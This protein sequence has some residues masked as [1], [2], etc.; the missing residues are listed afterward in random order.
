[1]PALRGLDLTIPEGSLYALLG[2][3]GAGKTTL[4]RILAGMLRPSAGNAVVLG[5]DA[6]RLGAADRQWLGYVAE[7]QRLPG[8]M[9]LSQLEAYLAPLYAT[10]DGAL[11]DALRARFELDPRR[12]VGT[13]SRGE[14][15]KATLLCVLAPRPRLLLMDEPFTGMDVLVKDEIVAGL[16]ETCGSEGWTVVI[17]SH[18]LAELELLADS[19]GFLLRGRLLL[20]ESMDT[21]RERFVRV[22]VTAPPGTDPLPA[23]VPGDWLS[24]ERSGQ[25]LTFVSS[26]AD[27][28]WS[29][30]ALVR[31]FPASSHIEARPATLKEV[32]LA[33]GRTGATGSPQ[34]DPAEVSA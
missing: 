24:V 4:M 6:A 14:Q 11:A 5:R 2:P 10:W 31:R 27:I 17:S 29:R 15:M 19:V 32:F 12:K 20:S 34:Q 13:L 23:E 28:T 30:D 16:L 22:E 3:N 9:T 25:R 7:S 18:D 21:V 8:W 26:A 1:V 33:L